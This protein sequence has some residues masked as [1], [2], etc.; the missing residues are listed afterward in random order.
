MT[1]RE[2][3]IPEYSDVEA[4]AAR[5]DGVAV[6]TPLLNSDI[7]DARLGARLFVKAECLQRTGSFKFRGAYN[8]LAQLSPA[9][10]Q[11]GVLAYSSG[12]HAQGIAAAAKL[13]GTHAKILMP[14]DAPLAKVQ[15]VEFWGGEVIRFD[16][17]SENREA[18]GARIA[19]EENRVIVPPYED[20][21]II[22]G[23]GTLGREA[24]LDLAEAGLAP[25]RL[26]CCA[27]GGG[28]IAGAGLAVKTL[29]PECEVWAAEPEGFDD[30]AHTLKTGERRPNERLTGSI[31]DAIL[32]PIHGALTWRL[33]EKQLSG[34]LAV[35]DDEAL[36]AMA[37]AWR[38]LKIVVE[39]GGAAALAAV[40][41]GKIDVK[42]Q[43]IIAV[44]TGGNV[45][46]NVFAR[47]LS[48]A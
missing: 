37:L 2:D 8:R 3:I 28:V 11:R 24:V 19:S 43:T 5:L 47:A 22:A 38:H 30:L 16:R 25:D 33:N 26:I 1:T 10:R 27:G 36:D 18:I 32:T 4:A 39:P 6:K 45:D 15:G 31:C 13:V 21:D 12:N 35:S 29:R 20:P 23:Q 48:R 9:E 40:L 44:A 41:S 7:L 14:A 17:S 46:Q 42:G 34:S